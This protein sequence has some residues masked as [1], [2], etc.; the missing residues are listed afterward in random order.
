MFQAIV[1]LFVYTGGQ[2]I[3]TVVHDPLPPAPT[4]AQCYS[5]GADILKVILQGKYAIVKAEAGCIKVEEKPKK[6]PDEKVEKNI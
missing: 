5:R 3:P 1:F 6:T 4:L 2:G